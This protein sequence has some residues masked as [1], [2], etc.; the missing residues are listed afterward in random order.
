MNNMHTDKKR[1]FQKVTLACYLKSNSLAN[2]ENYQSIKMP[3]RKTYQSAG[4]DFFAPY[5]FILEPGQSTLMATGIKAYM[6]ENEFLAIYIR[7]SLGT[8]KD[9]IMKNAVGIIDA[10]YYNNQNNEGHIFLSLKNNGT[11]PWIVTAGDAL[12]QGIFQQYLIVDDEEKELQQHRSG[13]FGS[14]GK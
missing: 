5:G 6:Q 13:G 14:T 4:Y 12:A 1:G 3:M 8:K 7:S 2:S 11:T 9:I 10:D